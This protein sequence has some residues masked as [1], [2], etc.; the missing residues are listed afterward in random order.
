MRKPRDHAAKQQLPCNLRNKE[1]RYWE[2]SRWHSPRDVT[3]R[4]RGDIFRQ[5]RFHI[6]HDAPTAPTS[7][8]LP[9]TSNRIRLYFA[10]AH[11]FLLALSSTIMKSSIAHMAQKATFRSRYRFN[12]D[13]DLLPMTDRSLPA[14]PSPPITRTA[15]LVLL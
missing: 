7:A 4:V 9:V 14:C 11:I 3:R 6:R 13:S 10:V 15:S 8:T 1:T 2:P 12:L 5:D